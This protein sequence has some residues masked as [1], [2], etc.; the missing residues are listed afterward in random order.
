ME[1]IRSHD[2]VASWVIREKGSTEAI[3]ETFSP[4]VVEKINTDKYEAIPIGQ[5]LA[6]LNH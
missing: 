2:V 6:N 4:T 3:L 1:P 5:Y